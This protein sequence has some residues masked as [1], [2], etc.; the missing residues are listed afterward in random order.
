M[1]CE[2]QHYA[3]VR[4]LKKLG[5]RVEND[6]AYMQIE[7]EREAREKLR[8]EMKQE[9]CKLNEDKKWDPERK[10]YLEEELELMD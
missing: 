8:S 4:S 2:H 7:D 3:E 6:E 5:H 10:A 9:L 1:Q